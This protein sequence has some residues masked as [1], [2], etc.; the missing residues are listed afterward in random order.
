MF[1]DDNF[2]SD[3]LI[4]FIS[5]GICIVLVISYFLAFLNYLD[6][7][8]DFEN[9]HNAIKDGEKINT[10]YIE[11]PIDELIVNEARTIE[12]G[13]NFLY[14]NTK[15]IEI[16]R[17]VYVQF[18]AEQIHGKEEDKIKIDITKYKLEEKYKKGD[19]LPLIK[20]TYKYNIRINCHY[21]DELFYKYELDEE[22]LK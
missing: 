8:T 20:T 17:S 3:P 21:N 1:D 16:P 7:K 11:L 18:V 22:R 14:K 10:E 5:I 9:L 15:V 12:K 2:F 19:L 13:W 6:D 4:Q